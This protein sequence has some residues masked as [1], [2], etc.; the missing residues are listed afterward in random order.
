MTQ[1]QD[2]KILLTGVSG[3]VGGALSRLLA[4]QCQLITAGRQSADVHISLDDA[5]SIIKGLEFAAPDIVINPAAYTQVDQ[6]ED[7][8]DAAYAVNAAAPGIIAEYC[9]K[10]TIPL[11]H[12]STDYVFSGDAQSPYREDDPTGPVNTYG[13]TKLAG[14]HAIQ[15]SGA[16]HLILRTCWVYDRQGKNFLNAIMN[17]A[18]SAGQLAVVNDQIGTPTSAN[19]LAEQTLNILRQ[20]HN[21]PELINDRSGIYHLCPDG[22]GSWFDFAQLIVDYMRQAEGLTLS[23]FDAVDS[24][25]FPTKTKR[26]SWS[27]LDNTKVKTDFQLH[28]DHWSNTAL[29]VL[30]QSS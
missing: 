26:P 28:F 3:Q 19:F 29:R 6:A 13:K 17:R 27:V 5:D 4:G 24:S 25:K 15:A 16:Q 7:D 9:K 20:I 21:Q 18:R 10:N 8:S 14:E 30:N 2:R 11:I 22:H 1:L 12:F 23:Q